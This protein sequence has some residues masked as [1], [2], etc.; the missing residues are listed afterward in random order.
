MR[1]IRLGTSV[2]SAAAILACG[3]L[4]SC[5]NDAT[6]NDPTTTDQPAVVPDVTSL[7]LRFDV[8]GDTETSCGNAAG[9]HVSIAMGEDTQECTAMWADATISDPYTGDA[10]D[11][12]AHHVAD[13]FF[14]LSPGEWSITDVSAIG[15]DGEPLECCESDWPSKALVSEGSTRE[16]G[17]PISCDVVGSG[18]LDI[19]GWLNL[20]P[21]ITNLTI[22]PSKFVTPCYPIALDVEATDVEGDALSYDWMVTDSPDGAD[23]LLDEDGAHADFA[24]DTEGDYTLAVTVTDGPHG[25][26]ASLEFPI[27]VSGEPDP[28]CDLG[29][30][31]AALQV[32]MVDDADPVTAGADVHMSSILYNED[33]SGE[34]LTDIAVDFSFG[35]PVV[36]P[37]MSGFFTPADTEVLYDPDPNVNTTTGQVTGTPSGSAYALVEGTDYDVVATSTGMQQLA[38][39]VDLAAD[40]AIIVNHTLDTGSATPPDDYDSSAVWTAN[41]MDTG[42][43]YS[44][45]TGESTTVEVEAPF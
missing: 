41:G 35:A 2:V 5:A 43:A 25:E 24:A 6:P 31:L 3:A 18:A 26:V 30:P 38:F 39:H 23:Y 19:Y 16:I 4:A 27:H 7:G 37:P 1:S 12:G 28:Q 40:A 20:P 34:S 22:S 14:V 33:D 11:D 10:A 45:L 29:G 13:C 32:Q 17:V 42:E 21:Y 8:V 9:V 36:T 15:D 44:A